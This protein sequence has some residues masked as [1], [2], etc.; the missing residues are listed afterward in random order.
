MTLEQMK[1][2]LAEIVAKLGE[3]NG[4]DSFTDEFDPF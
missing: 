2:R 1:A 4:L 3:F